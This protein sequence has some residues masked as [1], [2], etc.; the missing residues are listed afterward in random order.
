MRAKRSKRFLSRKGAGFAVEQA[1]S[2]A[3]VSAI[4]IVVVT[5][6]VG[7]AIDFGLMASRKMELQAVA[8]ATALAGAKQLTLAGANRRA[9][10]DVARSFALATVGRA[11]NISVD[12]T[13]PK[14]SMISVV[15]TE[16]WTAPFAGMFDLSAKEI[17]ANA[18]ATIIGDTKICMLAL[19]DNA[20]GAISL[21]GEAQVNAGSCGVYSNSTSTT[22]LVSYK[23]SF[24]QADVICSGG[25]V[26]G[27]S[28]NFDPTPVYD[29][30]RVAD[31][32]KSIEPPET[33]SCTHNGLTLSSEVRTLS[34]GIYCGGL[35]IYGSSKITLKPGIYVMKDGPLE[36]TQT[37]ALNGL[38]VGFYMTGT[39]SVFLFAGGST[40]ELEAPSGGPM[41]GLLFFEDRNNPAGRFHEIV[42]DNARRL[43]GT[44]YL[45]RGNFAVS[46]KRPVADQ[47]EYTVIIANTIQL[48]KYPTLVLNSDYHLTDVP[49]PTGLT[50]AGAEVQLVH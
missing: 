29:C 50:K 1:G 19:D 34:P 36:V 32:L 14:E 9:A 47:S 40:I 26:G 39:D 11:D 4:A 41:A 43:V 7:A 2:M 17:S 45:P 28:A 8:D 38:G 12:I 35:G 44:I 5:L 33:Y 15:I 24:L 13:S 3:A 6:A 30:P 42:S 23:N 22:S 27:S 25:G 10:A 16:R 49:V 46:S 31:P 20:S 37:S 21:T 48:N 18:G